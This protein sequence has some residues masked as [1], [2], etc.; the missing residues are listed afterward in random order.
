MPGLDTAPQKTSRGDQAVTGLLRGFL[1][2][3][4][5]MAYLLVSGA[6]T[7]VEASNIL[8]A[9][10]PEMGFLSNDR[11]ALIQGFLLHLGISGVYGAVFG[12]F[13]GWKPRFLPGWL[14][15]LLYGGLLLVV[16]RMVLLP[17]GGEGLLQI[18]PLHFAIAHLLYGILLGLKSYR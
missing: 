16:A 8:R 11:A 18:P 15:G 17:H 14:A 5:M 4:F 6:F 13:S 10:N 12:V 7:G 1:A 2:G 9:F 3:I